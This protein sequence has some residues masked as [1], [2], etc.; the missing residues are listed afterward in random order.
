MRLPRYRCATPHKTFSGAEGLTRTTH[1]RVINTLLCL[2]SYFGPNMALVAWIRTRNQ[3]F[4]KAPL[5]QLELHQ[6]TR[7]FLEPKE[8]IER[9]AYALRVRRSAN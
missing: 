3:C 8:R 4:T 7:S 1:L 5:C 2:M 6:Q 9:S